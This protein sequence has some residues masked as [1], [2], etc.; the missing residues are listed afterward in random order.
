MTKSVLAKEWERNCVAIYL[1]TFLP[2]RLNCNVIA[3]E[4][5]VCNTTNI[6]L[7]IRRVCCFCGSGRASV[8]VLGKP[9]K[10][11][12]SLRWR[13]DDFP[14]RVS[15]KSENTNTACVQKRSDSKTMLVFIFRAPLHAKCSLNFSLLV[16]GGYHVLVWN[17]KKVEEQ[18]LTCCSNSSILGG[19]TCGQGGSLSLSKHALASLLCRKFGVGCVTSTHSS[20]VRCT[21]VLSRFVYCFDTSQC[22]IPPLN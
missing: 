11:V 16:G 10:A 1:T 5:F 6:F 12:W 22:V 3:S 19:E 17:T 18:W 4:K 20:P 13:S 21:C 7:S 15:E 14:K 9:S 8:F 2:C